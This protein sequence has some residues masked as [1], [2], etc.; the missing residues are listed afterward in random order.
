MMDYSEIFIGVLILIVS[1]KVM[2][3][4]DFNDKVIN[5]KERK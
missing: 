2:Q 1:Y 5:K 3:V 4:I